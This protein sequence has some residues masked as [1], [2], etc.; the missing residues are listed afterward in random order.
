M[1]FPSTGSDGESITHAVIVDVML[2]LVQHILV[3]SSEYN[4]EKCVSNLY[5]L[6]KYRAT[7][8]WRH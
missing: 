4:V 1:S 6:F 3:Q 2:L 8:A 5:S 7:A